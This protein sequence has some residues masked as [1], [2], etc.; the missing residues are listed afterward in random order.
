MSLNEV[1][2]GST[3]SSSLGTNSLIALTSLLENVI[4]PIERT[5]NDTTIPNLKKFISTIKQTVQ[6]VTGTISIKLPPK[7]DLTDK[8][9]IKNHDLIWKYKEYVVKFA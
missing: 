6:Q 5:R 3:E 4:L 8:E 2:E 9:A 7:D 1:V